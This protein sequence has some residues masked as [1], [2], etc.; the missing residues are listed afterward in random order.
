SQGERA[1]GGTAAD[2]AIVDALRQI[3]DGLREL[4][5]PRR[6][7]RPLRRARRPG[8]TRE[9]EGAATEQ[10]EL[11]CALDLALQRLSACPR[12]PPRR[13]AT[14]ACTGPHGPIELDQLPVQREHPLRL[15]ICRRDRVAR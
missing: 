8:R 7:E 9:H 14:H 15:A 13:V 10:L 5:D 12:P 11:A 6:Q 1:L 4:A 2:L 3:A